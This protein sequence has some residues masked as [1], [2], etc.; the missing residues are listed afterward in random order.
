M[1]DNI[2][3]QVLCDIVTFFGLEQCRFHVGLHRDVNGGH[4]WAVDV[5]WFLSANDIFF[6]IGKVSCSP[7][8]TIFPFVVVFLKWNPANYNNNNNNSMLDYNWYI[9]FF[10]LPKAQCK[11]C[12][13]S[14]HVSMCQKWMERVSAQMW[15]WLW[16]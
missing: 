5:Y 1:V 12:K 11:D 10:W 3:V 7:W 14:L 6:C 8:I 9:F 13:S 2:A 4:W 15:H 16:R